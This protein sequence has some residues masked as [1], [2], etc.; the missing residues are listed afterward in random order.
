M[1]VTGAYRIGF[2]TADVTVSVI[3]VYESRNIK[4]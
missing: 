1:N 4:H 2:Q 3:S